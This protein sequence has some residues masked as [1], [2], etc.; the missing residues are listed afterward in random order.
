[1]KG[2]QGAYQLQRLFTHGNVTGYKGLKAIA[3]G[4]GD[5]GASTAASLHTVSVSGSVREFESFV[6]SKLLISSMEK[7]PKLHK[8]LISDNFGGEF[9][10]HISFVLVDTIRAKFQQVC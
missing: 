1:M 4:L 5:L 3:H 9:Q 10:S 6:I 7:L 2:L 8:I